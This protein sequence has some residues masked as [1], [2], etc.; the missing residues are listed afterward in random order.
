MVALIN[1][2]LTYLLTYCQYDLTMSIVQHLR[3]SVH[4]TISLPGDQLAS[5][6]RHAQLMRCFCA[7]AELLVIITQSKSL[8]GNSS[9]GCKKPAKISL[10]DF[11]HISSSLDCDTHCG[12]GFRSICGL[13]SYLFLVKHS[14][15]CNFVK[16]SRAANVLK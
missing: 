5:L 6:D 3:C 4:C 13:V 7:V 14:C 8:S 15:K 11:L 12:A 9:I 10:F 1:H 2:L 16:T